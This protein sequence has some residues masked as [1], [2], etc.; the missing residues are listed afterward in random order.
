MISRKSRK[1]W[2]STPTYQLVPKRQGFRFKGLILATA[3]LVGMISVWD[4]FTQPPQ[5]ST[6]PTLNT[7]ALPKSIDLLANQD[8]SHV[9]GV[10][11][12]SD[13][14][15]GITPLRR[16]IVSLDGNSYQPN[17]PVA[18]NAPHLEVSGEFRITAALADT[19]E[20]V[21][22]QFYGAVPVIYDEW[23]TQPPSIQLSISENQLAV[24][25]WDGSDSS[26]SEEH[27]FKVSMNRSAKLEMENSTGS[28]T[29]K[30]DGRLV[31]FLSDHEVFS[32]GQ[33]WFGFDGSREWTLHQL[34]AEA[35]GDGKLRLV[36]PPSM[37]ASQV[38]TG[39]LRGLAA[40]QPRSLAIGTALSFNA[41]FADESYR[42]LALGQFSMLTTENELKPQFIHPQPDIYSFAE[43]D[44]LIGTG[45]ANGMKVHGHTLVFGEANPKWMRDSPPTQ[46]R[47]IMVDHIKTVVGHYK[48]KISSWDVVNEPLADNKSG[49]TTSPDLRQHIWYRAMG[50]QYID[51][52]FKTAREADPNAKLYIND[53]GLEADGDRWDSLLAL[54]ARLKQRGVPIDGIGFQAHVYKDGDHIDPATLRRHIKTLAN[55]GL[56]SRISE[57]DVHGENQQVQASQY[58]GVLQ[59][60][61]AEPT[62]TAFSTW[63]IADK[64]GSTT[65][66]GS[67]PL[68]LG[69]DL[70]WDSTLQPK[71]AYRAL[72]NILR[73]K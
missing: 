36:S 28:L 40:K 12:K 10:Q 7:P 70:L 9:A 3:A 63:G 11:V 65:E 18:I 71:P 32:G 57:I 50:E 25:I 72:Q 31:G 48:G 6:M 54:V 52:A 68:E 42:T 69:D 34:R 39:S 73:P 20:N 21:K 41:L 23:R 24:M 43:A 44:S 61:L 8:W 30:L 53:W 60:C 15:L 2:F 35:Q 14:S 17:P 67:Y 46:L 51:I 58:S 22:I 5:P 62:C 38:E 37:E 26:P 66:I 4:I 55:L 49:D 56:A 47:Q 29:L 59:V 33:V 64:Y 45:L 13:G 1:S 19:G 16:A 27:T